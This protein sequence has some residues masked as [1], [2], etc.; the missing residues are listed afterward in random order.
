M[1]IRESGRESTRTGKTGRFCLVI[2]TKKNPFGGLKGFCLPD[3]TGLSYH[4]NEYI[5]PL[6]AVV[7]QYPETP[8]ASERR[9]TPKGVCSPFFMGYRFVSENLS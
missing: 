3:R 2:E 6:R 9:G 4:T 1:T 8:C 7:C 5:V